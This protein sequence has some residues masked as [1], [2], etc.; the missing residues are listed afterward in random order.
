MSRN[1]S[2]SDLSV[3]DRVK[4]V[5][6]GNPQ[7]RAN[8]QDRDTTCLNQ[9]ERV[10]EVPLESWK[11]IAADGRRIAFHSGTQLDSA[12]DVWVMKDNPPR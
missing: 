10:S 4:A 8:M 9:G 3:G 5:E 1:V 6:L 7:V 12:T 2:C 11:E